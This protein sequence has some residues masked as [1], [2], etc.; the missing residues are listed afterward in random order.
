MTAQGICGSG[1]YDIGP[2]SST[3]VEFETSDCAGVADEFEGEFSANTGVHTV[4][5]TNAGDE[6]GNFEGESLYT[7]F[8]GKLSATTPQ[9]I[10]VEVDNYVISAYIRGMDAEEAP[11]LNQD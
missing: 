6:P 4:Y 7:N 9:G 1:R 5:R 3:R 10:Q 11:C 2:T 8:R